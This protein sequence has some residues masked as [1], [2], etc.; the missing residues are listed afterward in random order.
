MNINDIEIGTKWEDT[1]GSAKYNKNGVIILK[2]R[3]YREVEIIEKTSNSIRY[4]DNGGFYSWITI[5]D[6]IRIENS[7]KKARFFKF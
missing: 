4:I 2:E 1:L 5:D 7:N 3:R 6:F